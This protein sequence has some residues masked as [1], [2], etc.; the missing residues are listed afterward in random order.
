MKTKL[1][2]YLFFFTALPSCQ[3]SKKIVELQHQIDFL[4]H[5]YLKELAENAEMTNT[6]IER[7]IFVCGPWI[8]PEDRYKNYDKTIT[9][10]S[11]KAKYNNL[12]D[13]YDDLQNRY[14]TAK[15]LTDSLTSKNSEM[16]MRWIEEYKSVRKSSKK[17]SN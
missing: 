16:V 4:E 3:T 8:N 9:F 5:Q 17:S 11:L 13:K 10:D 7:T 1:I 14:F 2:F 6:K 15:Q 12:V